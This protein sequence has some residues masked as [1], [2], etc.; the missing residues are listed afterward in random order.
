[1]VKPYYGSEGQKS[2]DPTV[3]FR[4]LLVGYLENIHSD[5]KLIEH[6]S[7]RLDILYLVDHNIDESLP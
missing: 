7:M 2:I 5:R 1:M 4:L 3:F 6:A